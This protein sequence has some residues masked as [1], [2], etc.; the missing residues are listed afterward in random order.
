MIVPAS[1][2]KYFW[3]VLTIVLLYNIF[4]LTIYSLFPEHLSWVW[5]E[6][7]IG[8]TIAALAWGASAVLCLIKLIFFLGPNDRFG[9][10]TWLFAASSLGCMREL[11]MH[12]ALNKVGIIWKLDWMGDD[13]V[14]IFLKM[15]MIGLFTLI[16]GGI[17]G[18]VIW[19]CKKIIRDLRAGNLLITLILFGMVYL[20]IGFCLDGSIL[21]KTFFFHIITRSFSKLAEETFETTAAVIFLLAV[22][23]FFAKKYVLSNDQ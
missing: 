17:L 21:G 15:V 20:A 3:F 14:S 22:L 23:P 18:S 16:G 8:E 12:K 13:S 4:A 5:S 19:N 7:N 2:E 1:R 6:G 11:D 10:W 9:V